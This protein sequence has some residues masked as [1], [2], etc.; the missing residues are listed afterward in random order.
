MS[1][2][3]MPES[4]SSSVASAPPPPQAVRGLGGPGLLGVRVDVVAGMQ[5]PPPPLL[6]QSNVEWFRTG[7]RCTAARKN[8]ELCDDDHAP[9]ARGRMRA[10]YPLPHGPSLSPS[11]LSV[12]PLSPQSPDSPVSAVQGG[13]GAEGQGLEGAVE[14][15]AGKGGGKG[16]RAEVGARQEA[17][18]EEEGVGKG[19][20]RG[21]PKVKEPRADPFNPAEF[22]RVDIS[23][24]E[25]ILEVSDTEAEEAGREGGKAVAGGHRQPA[26][27]NVPAAAMVSIL[28]EVQGKGKGKGGKGHQGAGGKGQAG[29]QGAG[30]AVGHTGR[31]GARG[32]RQGQQWAQPQQLFRQGPPKGSPPGVWA[33]LGAEEE[34]EPR[35]QQME[36]CEALVLWEHQLRRQHPPSPP[37]QRTIYELRMEDGRRGTE[38]E[39][40]REGAG[41][42]QGGQQGKGHQGEGKGRT[43][44]TEGARGRR[45]LRRTQRGTGGHG[46]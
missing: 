46:R 12:V 2:S 25:D 6:S 20:E 15:K 22:D 23:V 8:T 7:V 10:Q 26:A 17:V 33:A 40:G 5:A 16:G 30:R 32:G 3:P 41:K 42:R 35:R 43:E 28:P 44:W 14:G 31:A 38:E 18:E 19:G 9:V 21:E 1:Q 36:R 11:E 39:R 34:R 29:G 45:G 13:K 37:E 27:P 4:S 24:V